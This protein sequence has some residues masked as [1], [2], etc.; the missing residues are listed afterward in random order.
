MQ[1]GHTGL[2][3]VDCTDSNRS[4]ELRSRGFRQH[5]RQGDVPY[6]S[7]R[8]SL[9]KELDALALGTLRYSSVQ[10]ILERGLDQHPVSEAPSGDCL[11]S[12]HVNIRGVEYYR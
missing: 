9:Y 2:R 1:C 12:V 11:P 6:P 10:S 3:S 7:S 4:I 5:V 8:R